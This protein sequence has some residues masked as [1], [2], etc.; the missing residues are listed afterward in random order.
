MKKTLLIG[1]AAAAITGSAS[2][3]INLD[4]DYA[5]QAALAGHVSN[6]LD[7]TV[8]AVWTQAQLIVSVADGDVFQHFAEATVG[9]YNI[10]FAPIYP[11]IAIKMATVNLVKHQLLGI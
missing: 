8:D 1:A 6:I 7:V 11:D 3:T 2:A 4:I 10:L 5:P 9:P